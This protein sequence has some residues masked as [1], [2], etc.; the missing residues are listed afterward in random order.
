MNRVQ[1]LRSSTSGALPTAGARLPGEVFANFPDL[2]LGVIDGSKNPQK[3]IAV[4]FFSA[5]ANYAIGDFVVQA[6]SLTAP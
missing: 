6:G 1:V 2:Q 5:S 3:L 4:R